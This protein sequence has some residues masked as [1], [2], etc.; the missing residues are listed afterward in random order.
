MKR[1]TFIGTS[2]AANRRR[3]NFLGFSVPQNG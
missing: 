2:V 1:R 3:K